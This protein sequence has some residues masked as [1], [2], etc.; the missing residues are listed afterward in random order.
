MKIASYSIHQSPQYLLY[1]ISVLHAQLQLHAIYH[2]AFVE[3][4]VSSARQFLDVRTLPYLNQHIHTAHLEIRYLQ[5]P[6]TVPGP[7]MVPSES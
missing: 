5:V 6:R 1:H 4:L 2:R 7:W 3:M